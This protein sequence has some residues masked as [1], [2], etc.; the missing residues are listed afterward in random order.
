MICSAL[1]A[2]RFSLPSI[3]SLPLIEAQMPGA[4]SLF[5]LEVNSGILADWELIFPSVKG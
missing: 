2:T 4:R 1:L 5:G 3:K